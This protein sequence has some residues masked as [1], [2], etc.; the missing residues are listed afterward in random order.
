MM[1]LAE[2]DAVFHVVRAAEPA[3]MDVRGVDPRRH[4]V[5]HRMKSAKR[6]AIPEILQIVRIPAAPAVGVRTGMGN[7]RP[8]RRVGLESLTYV[9]SPDVTEWQTQDSCQDSESGASEQ[10]PRMEI[11]EK[12]SVFS[13]ANRQT[14]QD[15]CKRQGRVMN[16]AR[17]R[18]GEQGSNHLLS[19]LR[20]FNER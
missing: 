14:R 17:P 10:G 3:P 2:C 9:R 16:G 4:A 8:E 20:P 15:S 18:S 1:Q 11:N 12:L 19:E 13:F 5:Q 7:L 6:A